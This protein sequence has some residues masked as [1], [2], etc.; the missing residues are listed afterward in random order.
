M[1]V[2]QLLVSEPMT[3]SKRSICLFV[4]LLY[5]L[6]VYI[7]ALMHT[8]TYIMYLNKSVNLIFRKMSKWVLEKSKP[9]ISLEAKVTNLKLTYLSSRTFWEGGVFG[10][11]N[12]AG[13]NR[14]QQ[15]K[16][17]IKYEVDWLHTRNH[18]HEST[19]P[20]QGWEDRSLWASLIP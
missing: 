17:K 9:E 16:R 19:G 8:H 15:E 3:Q 7:H 2:K 13:E 10:K 11:D 12:A 4:H 6:T 1:T 14:R 5:N 18:R 20:E